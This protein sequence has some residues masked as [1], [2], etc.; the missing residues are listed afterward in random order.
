MMKH[1][2]GAL[3]LAALA[4][5]A[6]AQPITSEAQRARTIASVLEGRMACVSCDL[7]Q[8]DFG[9]QDLHHRNFAGA[10]LRDAVLTVATLDHANLTGADLSVVKAFGAR[11]EH[12]NFTRANLTDANA[13]GAY[14]G[15]A[16][17]TGATLTGAVLSGADLSLAIGLTQAQLNRACGDETTAL[18]AGMTIPACRDR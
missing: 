6:Q 4:A 10:R 18:P 1:L 15:G 12:A 13:V 9:Y 8:A 7:F 3:A 17:L 2:G 14:F 16:R 11:F 5:V